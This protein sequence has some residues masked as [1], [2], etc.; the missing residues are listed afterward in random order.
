[1]KNGRNNWITLAALLA[2]IAIAAPL[3][4]AQVY[5]NPIENGRLQYNLGQLSNP[6]NYAVGVGRGQA[7][8]II[9]AGAG[10]GASIG[11]G[12]GGNRGAAIGAGAG[13]VVSGLG[14]YIANRGASGPKPVDCSKARLSKKEK[15]ACDAAA[16]E[17]ELAERAARGGSLRNATRYQLEV[18]DCGQRV[19]VLRPGQTVQAIEASCGYEGTMFVPSQIP[20]RRDNRLAASIIAD[21]G[22]GWVFHEPRLGGG[23]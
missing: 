22:N 1:M 10:T 19:T 17:V 5:V 9:A 15:A 2:L 21:S 6:S 7:V 8:G 18:S 20:G 23:R 16:A 3:A 4:T 11:Y 12:L 13:A 14:V